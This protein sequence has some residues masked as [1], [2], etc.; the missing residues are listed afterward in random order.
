MER[1][2]S[3]RTLL[4]IGIALLMVDQ[5]SKWYT[6]A[7]IPLIT[8]ASPYYPFGGIPVFQNFL[9]VDFSLN[10][11]T[12][13]GAAWGKLSEF[14]NL[15]LIA[16]IVMIGGLIYTILKINSHPGRTLPLTL[17]TAGAIGNVIDVFVY[18]HVVDMFH[19]ILWGYDFPIFNVADSAICIGVF[20]LIAVMQF[21]ENKSSTCQK[22]SSSP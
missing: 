3:P 17:I 10:Y 7:Y 16:R 2:W 6:A 11:L 20:W 14:Q 21:Q 12:N 13:K 19:F 8:F 5:L 1:S 15:L 4:F 22:P 9:G 18:G